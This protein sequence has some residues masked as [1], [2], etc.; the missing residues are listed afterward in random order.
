VGDHELL[1]YS[2][3]T[4]RRWAI[5]EGESGELRGRRT[6]GLGVA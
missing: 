4:L 6:L 5:E 3:R 1:R 2:E